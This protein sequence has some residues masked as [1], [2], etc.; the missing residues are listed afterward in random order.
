M[1]ADYIKAGF[2]CDKP[3]KVRLVRQLQAD[4]ARKGNYLKIDLQENDDTAHIDIFITAY[5]KEGREIA[6]YA[7]EF[8]ER[9][10]TAHTDCFDWVVEDRKEYWLKQAEKQGYTPL[11][12]Y[13]WSDDYYALWNINTWDKSEPRP[14]SKKR[15]T[16]GNYNESKKEYMNSFV[17]LSS[18]IKQGY[19]N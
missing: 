14:I 2:Q 13:L 11:Y 3:G 17:T 7:I 5:T 4:A 9:P 12:S 1:T 8:K 16:M 15:H 10:D 19:L 6:T 18:A